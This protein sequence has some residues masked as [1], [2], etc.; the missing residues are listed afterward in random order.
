MVTARLLYVLRLAREVRMLLQQTQ[1]KLKEASLVG[2][3]DLVSKAQ[4]QGEGRET[5]TSFCV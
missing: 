5:E 2:E 4:E 1:A 3:R